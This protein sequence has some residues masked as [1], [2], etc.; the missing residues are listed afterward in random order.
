MLSYHDFYL[1]LAITTMG[2]IS[3]I[4]TLSKAKN[5]PKD[6]ILLVDF[7]LLALVD[8]YVG[9]VYLAFITGVISS[10]EQLSIYVR[11]S[12]LLLVVLPYIITWRMGA[13]R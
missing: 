2:I 11:P 9:F 8:L 10:T 13:I 1:P 4:Y 12:L 6:K 7:V 5:L 3:G